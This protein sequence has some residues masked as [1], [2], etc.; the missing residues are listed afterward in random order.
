MK[1]DSDV[2]PLFMPSFS[3]VV[4]GDV[5]EMCELITIYGVYALFVLLLSALDDNFA[6]LQLVTSVLVL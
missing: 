4:H 3:D 6:A 5:C 1:G 2:L